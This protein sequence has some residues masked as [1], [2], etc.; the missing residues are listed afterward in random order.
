MRKDKMLEL[1]A[2]LECVITGIGEVYGAP[3]A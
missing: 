1:L 2:D 3:L